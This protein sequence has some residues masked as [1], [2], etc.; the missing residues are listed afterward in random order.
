LELIRS[1]DV[2][3]V[4]VYRLDRLTRDL[5]HFVSLSGEFRDNNVALSIVAAPEL[6]VA[7]LDGLILNVLAS[8]AE[9]EREMTASRIAKRNLLDFRQRGF[10]ARD[11]AKDRNARQAVKSEPAR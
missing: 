5:R 4:V 7:A 6:G 8:F 2:D 9:F 11:A 10:P 3:R 1:R